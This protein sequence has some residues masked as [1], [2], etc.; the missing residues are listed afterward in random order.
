MD[1]R[2]RPSFSFLEDLEG[3]VDF[4]GLSWAFPNSIGGSGRLGSV[5]VLCSPVC[6]A[7]LRLEVGVGDFAEAAVEGGGCVVASG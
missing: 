5:D 7:G 2:P 6:R 3:G 1:V 4:F